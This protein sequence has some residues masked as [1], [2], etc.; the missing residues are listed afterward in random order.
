MKKLLIIISV[1]GMCLMT[2]CAKK[3]SSK[4][5]IGESMD[6]IRGVYKSPHITLNAVSVFRDGEDFVVVIEENQAASGIIVFSSNGKLLHAEKIVPINDGNIKEFLG[7]SIENLRSQ[8]GGIHCDIGSGFYIPA[9]ITDYATIIF[10]QIEDNMIRSISSMNIIT[11]S[12]TRLCSI[13]D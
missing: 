2:G 8:Y 1:I 10:F 11:K 3:E 9:Y 12:T 6:K 13:D 4:I 5:G 7:K